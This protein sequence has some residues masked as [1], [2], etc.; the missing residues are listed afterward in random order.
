[1]VELDKEF[2][3]VSNALRQHIGAPATPVVAEG[4]IVTKGQLI[5]LMDEGKLG[6]NVHASISGKVSQLSDNFVKIVKYKEEN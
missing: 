5:G 6:A 3:T 2:D 4:D 1:M